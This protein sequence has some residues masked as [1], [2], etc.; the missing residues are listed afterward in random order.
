MI[1]LF[2]LS[3]SGAAQRW[4]ASL[5]SSRRRTWDDLAQEFLRQFS[6]NTVVDVS[7]RELEALM[8]R[9][10]ESV[11]SFIPAGAEDCRDYDRPSE[12]DQIQ[13]VLRSLQPRIARH[14]VGSSADFCSLCFEDIEA[15]LTDRHAVEPGSS[16]AYT[17]WVIDYSHPSTTA[18]A[19]SALVQ[20]GS[21]LCIPSGVWTPFILIPDVEE[22]QAPYVDDSQTLD[23][24]YVLREVE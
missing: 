1:T 18:S 5:E 21:T 16:K 4:F 17:G 2:P 11:S 9:L 12:R 19:D 8:Q 7:R 22:V 14:V 20:D 24:H 3:L 15:V 6:F 10:D 13:M 23:I